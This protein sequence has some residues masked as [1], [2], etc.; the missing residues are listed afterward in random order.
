MSQKLNEK[1]QD[2]TS[3]NFS[4][5]LASSKQ[6]VSSQDALN[7][8]A[9]HLYP[10]NDTFVSK[11]INLAPTNSR[12]HIKIGRYSN[13]KTVPSP[14]NGYFDSKVLSRAHAEVWYENEKVYI[15]DIKSSNG[16]FINGTRLSPES[17]E[18]EPFELHSEDVVDFGI[19]ILT[20]DNKDIL[21]RRVACRV[22][23]VMTPEDA[24]K[25]RSDFTSLYRGGVHG[26]SL[27]TAG[28][29]PGAE[30]GFRRNKSNV[31][32]DQVIMRLQSELQKSSMVGSD[33]HALGTSIQKIHDTLEGGAVPVQDAP[34]QELVPASAP[35]DH[36]SDSTKQV[37]LN[38]ASAA[39]L[40]TQL[41]NT[42]NLL[43][44]HVEKIKH[45]E[46]TLASYERVK[47][48]FS[49]LK[50]EVEEMRL[51]L[52]NQRRQEDSPKQTLDTLSGVRILED[53]FDDAT[54]VGSVETVVADASHGALPDDTMTDHPMDASDVTITKDEECVVPSSASTGSQDSA[55][56]PALL[57]RIERL[58]KA[59][60]QQPQ[61]LDPDASSEKTDFSFQEWK[62]NFERRWEEQTLGWK[63]AQQKINDAFESRSLSRTPKSSSFT[64]LLIWLSKHDSEMPIMKVSIEFLCKLLFLV[65]ST[66]VGV[67][68][69][70]GVAKLVLIPLI[71][72]LWG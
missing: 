42:H 69:S 8:P 40:E 30:G 66:I 9:L 19:D 32:V 28:L 56:I 64:S 5:V 13:N 70:L 31:N 22:F 47:D 15:K 44:S 29:C 17:Q 38:P 18:S 20:D 24:L 51:E 46:E 12:E 58:E 60:Q 43:A 10:L 48:E 11:Q 1:A 68:I 14:V 63:N 65:V 61:R 23:L 59:L 27:G 16:T 35:H 3:H 52:R 55:V 39:S 45:L 54:S 49:S 57:S 50:C 37:Q 6:P 62:N 34:Y 25:L 53:G 71:D 67:V 2:A 36:S 4:S 26:G 21:H 33:L 41:A 72:V 7:Y